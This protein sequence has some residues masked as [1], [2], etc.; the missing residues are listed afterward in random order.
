[1]SAMDYDPWSCSAI[2][3]IDSVRGGG[4]DEGEVEEMKVDEREQEKQVSPTAGTQGGI[5]WPG[6]GIRR[7]KAVG[8]GRK[9]R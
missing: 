8:G 3:P 9:A 2:N 1:M 6:E 4:G 5:V 7:G